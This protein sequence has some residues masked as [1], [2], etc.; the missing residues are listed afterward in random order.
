MS[1]IPGSPAEPAVR[2][3]EPRVDEVISAVEGLEERPL[4]EHVAVFE[5]AHDELRR[6]LDAHRDEARDRHHPA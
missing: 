4:E 3:G 6:A 5:R 2:T 1:E